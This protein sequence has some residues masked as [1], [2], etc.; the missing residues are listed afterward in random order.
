MKT[1]STVRGLALGLFILSATSFSV[2]VQ[3][4]TE[5]TS[6]MPVM[7][8]E[9]INLTTNLRQGSN[10]AATGNQVTSLQ[11]FLVSKGYFNAVNLGSGHFG[12]LTYK[13]TISYQGSVQL[14]TTGFVGP[15]T[16]AAI[17]NSTCG[18]TP[19]TS[20]VSLYRLSP[21][22][23]AVGDTISITGFGMT[24]NNT[25]LMGGS[26]A[27]RNVPITASVAIAC[28]TNPS[29]HGGINQTIQLV[30]PSTVG[31]NCPIGSLC[32]LYERLVTPGTYQ[33]TV[34]ND[35][36]TSN[37]LSLTVATSSVKTGG[38]VSIQSLDT[39]ATL[40][41]GQTGAWTVHATA[42]STVSTLHYSVVWGDE[43]QMMTTNTI[44][45]PQPVDSN[46]AATF[47]HSYSRSGTHTAIFT[48]T[49]DGGHS[50]SASNTVTVTPIY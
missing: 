7:M 47:T 17:K 43:I 34:V 37:A 28:T 16:R 31:P 19:P 4:Q 8:T 25:V 44:V 20:S 26:L 46:N 48:V 50:V 1:T 24:Q 39:P 6:V 9:C 13:A 45:A 18:T 38:E 42:P 3:A 36:G 30:I 21:T 15:L 32:P 49:D 33:V 22:I 5:I 41:I 23:A 40:T 2:P 29:C 10:D 27:M 14:P 12:P 11:T 35:N